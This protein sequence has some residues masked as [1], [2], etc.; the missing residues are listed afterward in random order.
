VSSVVARRRDR[1]LKRISE[2]APLQ[3]SGSTAEPLHVFTDLEVTVFQYGTGNI[4]HST[5]H[6]DRKWA[7]PDEFI[8]PPTEPHIGGRVASA[9]RPAPPFLSS[10]ANI[11]GSLVS[12]GP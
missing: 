11:F 3:G 1:P 4:W 10:L 8:G 5:Q 9:A 7:P 6:A 12:R 2:R